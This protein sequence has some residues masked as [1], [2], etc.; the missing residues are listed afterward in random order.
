MK[1]FC[2]SQLTL[3]L[4]IACDSLFVR[5]RS[6]IMEPGREQ[7]PLHFEWSVPKVL[8]F[9]PRSS[10][11]EIE[12]RDSAVRGFC[13]LWV[14]ISNYCIDSM[15]AGATNFLQNP[16]LSW[17][18]VALTVLIGSFLFVDVW[19]L[20]LQSSVGSERDC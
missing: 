12:K 3:I 11:R 18:R 13:V 14:S 19:K 10:T 1:Q 20:F 17:A 4:Q 16:D 15:Q 5:P 2:Y 9:V 6:E 8:Y 7:Q